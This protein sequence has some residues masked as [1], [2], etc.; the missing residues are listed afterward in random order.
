M[1]IL[2]RLLILF[3]TRLKILSNLGKVYIKIVS[4]MYAE[5]ESRGK[6]LISMH[7]STP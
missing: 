2:S 1:S 6:S 3:V 5:T 7:L 4:I